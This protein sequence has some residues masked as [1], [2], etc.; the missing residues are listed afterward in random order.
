M[1]TNY[2]IYF[3]MGQLSNKLSFPFHSLPTVFFP[4]SPRLEN[5]TRKG[6]PCISSSEHVQINRKQTHAQ[7]QQ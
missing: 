4:C 1:L 3:M 2:L 5:L 6:V 7:I